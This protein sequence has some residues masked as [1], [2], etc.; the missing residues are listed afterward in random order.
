MFNL[1]GVKYK[2]ILQ[3]DKLT[4]PKQ[5]ITSIVGESGSGKTTLLKLLNKMIN[6]DGGEIF[7]KGQSL[8]EIDPIKLRREVVMLPQNPPI[9]MGTVK[10]NL[11]IGLQFSEK[12]N[13]DNNKLLEVLKT[14][15]LEKDLNDNA[16]NL[17]GGEKQRL[18]LG[19]ILL[20]EPEVFLLDEP[21]SALD[22]ETE[23]YVI[24]NLVQYIKR[25]GKTLVMITHSSKVADTFS[26]NIIVIE[27]GKIKNNE[28]KITDGK[29]Y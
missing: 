3:I 10:D 2:D 11:L 21:S 19:R 8:E 26:D 25:K 5:R 7:F 16:N 1:M 9:F 27:K 29:N 23:K 24:E 20:M 13:V 12:P 15:Y 18:A 17:S 14:V 6:C 4:I 22:E 28:V